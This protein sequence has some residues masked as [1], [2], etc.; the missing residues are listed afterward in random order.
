MQDPSLT[1]N[2]PL[3]EDEITRSVD[4]TECSSTRRKNL[5]L[6]SLLSGL[7]FVAFLVACTYGRGGRHLVGRDPSISMSGFERMFFGGGGG[8][9]GMGGMGGIPGM[10]GMG[11]KPKKKADTTKFYKLLG[12]DKSAGDAD[13][14][15]A[16]RKMAMKEHPD[17][18]GDPE[19][20]K[21]IT[22][23]YEILS[24]KDKR[25]QYDQ[26][27]EEGLEGA[28]G[29]NP[30]DIFD[31]LF[32]GGRGRGGKSR[33]KTEDI[34]HPMKVTLEQ[35]YAGATK[36][37]A[38]TRQVLDKERGVSSCHECGGKGTKV[39]VVR[40]GP[41]IQQMQSECSSCGGQGKSF[42]LKSEREVL[43]IFIAKG[44]PADHKVIFREKSDEH[45]DADTG[46]VIFVLKEQD[47]KLFKRRGADLFVEKTIS[48]VE[49]LCGF[50]MELEHLDG[51]K[52]L[53]KTKPGDIV[54]PAPANFDP[55]E[56]GKEKE[57]EWECMEGYDCPSLDNVAQAD[58]T[59]VNTLKKAVETQLKKQGVSVGAFVVDGR[60]AY[61]KSATR[62][63][64][65]D[66]KRPRSGCTMYVVSDP[67]EKAG[68]RMF[69]AVQGEGMPTFKEPL[70]KGNLILILT[71]DFPRSLDVEK[72][73]KIRELL[74]PALHKPTVK[75]T[76]EG[77]ETFE[78]TDIDPVKSYQKNEYNMK[79]GGDAY[80]E[81]EDAGQG[82][83][84]MGGQQGAQ[85]AQ[86]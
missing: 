83:P 9:P 82:Q 75:E 7:G 38:I 51:R 14:K 39:Q 23:A 3:L 16:Y 71:I 49:A 34:V 69:K 44:S 58:T 56:V 26:Y 22:K 66:A 72:Q 31:A 21:E 76:D 85:C 25:A 84:G 32:G 40:M 8:F 65:L 67:N 80:D 59:D 52:L 74:P 64:V 55:L 42:R 35:L 5:V 37:M 79:A 19:K 54:C 43:E 61:F 41:M 77:V 50:E 24:N 47:H 30:N 20:F 60:R 12:V 2:E 18:G 63:E 11:Q 81:D 53:I 68:M 1:F 10:D 73:N 86:M 15:K 28:A 4:S 6:L 29:G 46:D 36:K 62:Q 45:P 13:I 48:L 57:M 33:K 70:H 27:G 17:K 78:L